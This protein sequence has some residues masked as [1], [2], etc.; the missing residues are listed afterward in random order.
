M[1]LVFG[2]G[3][4]DPSTKMQWVEDGHVVQCPYYHLWTSILRR[5]YSGVFHKSNPTYVGCNVCDEWHKFENFR[6][7][8][9][10]QPN[11]LLW[12]Y[13]RRNVHLDKDIV[14]DG[15][16]TP[17]GCVF[18][19]RVINGLFN[20]HGKDD[21][22]PL[23]VYFE[24]STGKWKSQISKNGKREFLG[25]FDSMQDAHT[26]WVYAKA[27]YIMVTRKEYLLHGGNDRVATEL[28]RRAAILLRLG[29]QGESVYN[30]GG[31]I[32]SR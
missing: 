22:V 1:K 27:E 4:K 12:L 13:D 9:K 21:T 15:N 18:V 26:A 23:G 3:Y 24:K 25:R 2:V 20:D 14:G 32:W 31:D 8:V 29:K 28:K 19:P 7:W 17:E 30:F 6:D 5:S 10:S 16:Y 11:R